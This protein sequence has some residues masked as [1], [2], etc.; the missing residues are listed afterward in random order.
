MDAA[1]RD[2]TAHKGASIVVAGDEQPAA[3]HALAHAINQA[4]GNAGATVI[5]T[6]PVEAAPVDQVESLRTLTAD[7][8]AGAVDVLLILGGNPVYM[9]PANIRFGDALEKVAFS[10]RLGQ[11]QDETSAKCQ[12]HVPES[13]SSKRG[14]MRARGMAPPRSCSR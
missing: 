3:V 12:W 9:A 4:L 7:M 11:Y 14:A 5:Y 8:N 2:L 13:H 1:A 10:A 6:D